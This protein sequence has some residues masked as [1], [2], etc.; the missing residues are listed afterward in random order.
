MKIPQELEARE[1]WIAEIPFAASTRGGGY[2]E[3]RCFNEEMLKPSTTIHVIEK[4]AYDALK[5]QYLASLSATEGLGE[6]R[7]TT[8]VQLMKN[9][10]DNIAEFGIDD[11]LAWLRARFNFEKKELAAYSE[12][13][14]GKDGR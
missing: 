13:Q 10:F 5:A 7:L 9:I 1:F 11:T 2:A 8:R 6:D 3:Y 14:G 4:S 12:A